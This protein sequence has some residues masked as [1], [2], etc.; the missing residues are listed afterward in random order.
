[1][2]I[3]KDQDLNE[4]QTKIFDI[5][6]GIDEHEK[7]AKQKQASQKSLSVRR[8]IEERR[9][10]KELEYQINDERWFDDLVDEA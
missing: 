3:R 6:V 5:I 4:I 7:Q 10:R 2:L 1:M 8:A 9:Q